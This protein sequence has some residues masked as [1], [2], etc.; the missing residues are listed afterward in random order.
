[1]KKIYD[2]DISS[3]EPM[4]A[5][6]RSLD[7]YTQDSTFNLLQELNNEMIKTPLKTK[8]SIMKNSDLALSAGTGRNSV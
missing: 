6:V 3:I 8:G 5:T 2:S 4:P 1:M 7:E